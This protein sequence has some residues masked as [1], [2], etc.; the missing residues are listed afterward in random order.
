[1]KKRNL[2]LMLLCTLS[3]AGWAQDISETEAQR[4][5]QQFLSSSAAG[6]MRRAPA[7]TAGMRLAHRVQKA[8]DNP[9]LYVFNTPDNTGF[10]IVAGDDRANGP[11]LG[12]SDRGAFDIEK[13]PGGLRYLLDFYARGIAYMR[14][15]GEGVVTDKQSQRAS[16]DLPASVAPL[17]N[18][19]WSQWSPYNDDCPIGPTGCA[20]TALAQIM[21]YH[22]WPKQ[23]SG[24][25]TN[26]NYSG[27]TVNFSESTYDWSYMPNNKTENWTD[28]HNRAV[29]KLMADVGC[30]VDMI[31]T[32]GESAAYTHNV[33][34]ALIKN[35]GYDES[36]VGKPFIGRQELAAGRPF[37][38]TGYDTIHTQRFIYDRYYDVVEYTTGH[39]FVCDGYD[40]AGMFHYNFGWGGSYDGYY[41]ENAINPDRP[42]LHGKGFSFMHE[43]IGGIKPAKYQRVV[44]NGVFYD[45]IDENSVVVASSNGAPDYEG[46]L[47]IPAVVNI[48]GTNY[49]VTGIRS[50]AFI[51]RYDENAKATKSPN[52]TGLTIEA[53]MD[54]LPVDIFSGLTGL[55]T[56]SIKNVKTINEGLFHDMPNLTTLTLGEGVEKIGAR[57]FINC[58][59][60]QTVTLPEGLTNIA[61]SAFFNCKALYRINLPEG[62]K[63]IG[64][65]SFWSTG[66][67]WLKLP[68]SLERMGV[69]AFGNGKVYGLD[70]GLPDLTEIPDSAFLYSSLYNLEIPATVKRIGK[71]AF[72][73]GSGGGSVKFHGTGF[74]I[75][76]NAFYNSDGFTM[77]GLENAT[78]IMSYG[79]RGLKGKYTVKKGTKLHP[80]SISGA[81][82]DEIYL[83]ADVTTFDE[84]S[85]TNSRSYRVDTDNPSFTACDSM[86]MNKDCSRLIVMP[87]NG[88][89]SGVIPSTVTTVGPA[90]FKGMRFLSVPSGVTTFEMDYS[91]FSGQYNHGVYSLNP[92]PPVFPNI[93]TTAHFDYGYH[94]KLHVPVGSKEAYANAPVWRDFPYILDDV[95][96]DDNYF[97]ELTNVIVNPWTNE[98]SRYATAVGRNTRAK[99]NGHAFIP[100]SAMIG[101]ERLPVNAIADAVFMGDRSLKSFTSTHMLQGIGSFRG[102]D[103]LVSVELGIGITTI[104]G[105]EGCTALSD[106]TIRGQVCYITD[107]AFKGCTSLKSL[108]FKSSLEQIRSEAFMGSG[109]E[110][111]D[112][113]GNVQ[114]IE[115]A[116]FKN[117]ANL[118]TVKGMESIVTISDECFAGSG[119]ETIKVPAATTCIY[120]SAFSDC[121]QLCAIEVD[122]NNTMFKSIHGDLY[123]IGN[124]GYMEL[125]AIHLG[126]RGDD[127]QITPRTSLY[128]AS[129]CVTTQRNVIPNQITDI[130]LP[131]SVLYIGWDSFYDC[132]NLKTFTNLSTTPQDIRSSDF[133][134]EI[135][136]TC[137]LQV[138][139]GSKEAYEQATNWNRFKNIVEIDPKDFVEPEDPKPEEPKPEVDDHMRTAIVVWMK[140][141]STHTF[142][143]RHEPIITVQ[144]RNLHIESRAGTVEVPLTSVA[145]YTF[146]RYDITGVTEMSDEKTDV[147]LEHNQLVVTGLKIGDNVDVYD[148]SGKLI[149]HVQSRRNG[150]YRI[151][152]SSLPTG[153]YVVKANQTTVKFMKR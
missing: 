107:A 135:F 82:F 5:A 2:I 15:T 89:S 63:T 38:I 24:Q 122:E 20:A 125:Y 19:S 59:K 99:W 34:M 33:F 48:E 116:L 32:Y 111:I 109:L 83:P 25:H 150:S 65:Q 7:K 23:G 88:Y 51:G 44:V 29:A 123:G 101:D 4:I 13:A 75:D 58:E 100:S 66:I 14:E 64:R 94:G 41:R 142:Y 144:N 136:E 126:E 22:K 73:C 140:D 37:Y 147:S 146:D 49:N 28:R 67:G 115:R 50:T 121:Q 42:D 129:E 72:H 124:S 31:Y 134:Y 131:A 30:A 53:Q 36:T 118:K 70:G 108:S 80:Y 18:T 149:Q 8:V 103:S 11:V 106:I 112:L 153:V 139:K 39:A 97:Y 6:K 110:K 27:Q 9:E 141:G 84:T 90:A 152:L 143:L 60:L 71:Y 74:T 114:Y 91:P 102:C 92:T 119:I 86:L 104:G 76:E 56:L 43:S 120:P 138:P 78:E 148:V 145:R 35:F 69:G 3:L 16:D 96:C 40:A 79:I 105:F 87:T 62:L 12:Y 85:V 128:I 98:R 55:Q 46:D 151:N 1:M 133:Y 10:V 54:N 113:G 17:L 81:P 47:T 132:R 52:L 95:T 57:A 68:R 21:N 93:D 77:E 45:I 26:L 61:D 137:T 130:V 127:G 117:C